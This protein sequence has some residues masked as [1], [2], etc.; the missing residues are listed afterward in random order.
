MACISSLSLLYHFWCVRRAFS[1]YLPQGS[2]FVT[3]YYEPLFTKGL[4]ALVVAVFFTFVV[5]Q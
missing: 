5:S 1:P 4:D 3:R 2:W